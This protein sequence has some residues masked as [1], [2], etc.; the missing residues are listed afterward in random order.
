MSSTIQNVFPLRKE[1]QNPS[2]A[3]TV[4]REMTFPFISF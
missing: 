2:N 3:N 4:G 1:T